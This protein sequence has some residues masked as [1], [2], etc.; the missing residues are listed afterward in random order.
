MRNPQ[1]LDLL[2]S[3]RTGEARENI[4]D[5]VLASSSEI[6]YLEARRILEANYGQSPIVVDVYVKTVTED[7]GI[8][9]GDVQG[10]SQLARAM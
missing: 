9:A 2:I 3:S 6:G 5:C 4:Q 1:K 7:P 8:R 10:L